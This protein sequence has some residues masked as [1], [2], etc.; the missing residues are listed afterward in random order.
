MALRTI[1]GVVD[2]ANGDI[3]ANSRLEFVLNGIHIDATVAASSAVYANIGAG[4]NISVQLY[5][6]DVGYGANRYN[7][8]L[9][10]YSDASYTK[11][12]RR[13]GLGRIF[14][15]D[16]AGQTLQQLLALFTGPADELSPAQAA[17]ATA[18]E[19]ASDAVDA[20]VA[21]ELAVGLVNNYWFDDLAAV[22]ADTSLTYSGSGVVVVAG[23]YV[24]TRKENA[25]LRVMSSASTD[26]SL[27]NGRGTPVK[28]AIE[29]WPQDDRGALA[30]IGLRGQNGEPVKIAGFGDSSV[31]GSDCADINN[32]WTSRVGSILRGMTGNTEIACYNSGVGGKKIIDYWARDNYQSEVLA[33]WPLTEYV[34]VCFGLNDVKTDVAPA[35]DVDLFRQRYAELIWQ[36]RLS[37]RKAII[38]TPWIIS[39]AAIRP[40]ALIQAELLNAVKQVAQDHKCDLLDTNAMLQAWWR[41]DSTN[42]R[43]GDQQSDGTH[44]IDETHINIGQ[45]V[46]R[47]IYKHRVID[48]S[49]GSRLGPHNAEWSG[50]VTVAYNYNMNNAFGFSAQL[51]GAASVNEAAMI[52]VWSDRRRHAIYLSPDRSVVSGSPAPEAYVTDFG[53]A[54]SVGRAIEFGV[55]GTST[56]NRPA[57]NHFYVAE[58]PFG[59]SALRFDLAAAGTAEYGGWLVVDGFNQ[60]DFTAYGASFSADAIFLP[61]F[62]DSNPCVFPRMNGLAWMSIDAD[63]LPA[64]WGVVIASQYVYAN[65]TD[66]GPNRRMQSIVA[67]KG[68]SGAS[69]DILRVIHDSTGII[70]KTSIKTSGTGAWAGHI[71]IH[72]TTSTG[73]AGGNVLINV[74]SDGTIIATHNSGGTGDFMSPYGRIGGLFR[75]NSIA[76]AGADGRQARAVCMPYLGIA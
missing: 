35:W 60:I 16:T 73:A 13:V 6:N 19:A 27:T 51:T 66:Y 72:A 9:V 49:H 22:Q 46:V 14:V 5:P 37:G 3:P 54:G 53:G 58:I 68:L 38:M 1:T 39:A 4:G 15:E 20:K 44:Y 59:L 26:Q 21:A 2:Y 17:A 67:L 18:I 65:S 47:E 23:D 48:V 61:P 25:V 36:I 30:E 10:V 55:A 41:D 8:T 11:E 50:D 28:F 45:F 76:S 57:E 71:S 56:T 42:F 24:M 62:N 32:R 12:I 63:R 52:W 33:A 70:S 64:G 34:I 69:A 43:I 7:V 29:Y 31:L 40:H 74:R 75:D